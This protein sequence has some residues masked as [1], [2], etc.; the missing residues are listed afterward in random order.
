M[1]LTN[2]ER[3]NQTSKVL[4]ANVY[5]GIP[6]RQWYEALRANFFLLEDGQVLTEFA[7]VRANPAGSLTQARNNAAGP[8]TGIVQDLS[9]FSNAV[10]L[11]PDIAANGYQYV[12]LATYNDFS[13]AR[14]DKWIQPQKVPQT[15]GQPSIGY[16][17]QLYDG[18][19][20]AGGTLI[21][22]SDGQTGSG[23]TASVGWLFNYDQGVLILS[24]DFK[25]TISDPYIVGFRYIGET[26]KDIETGGGG[27]T[28]DDQRIFFTTAQ[29]AHG[30]PNGSQLTPVYKTTVSGWLEAQANSTET[31]AVG[32]ITNAPDVDT[33]EITMAGRVTVS[34]HS[35]IVNEYYFLDVNSQGALTVFTP[36]S[37]VV[38]PLLWV[39][40]PDTVI[41]DIQR[42]N[43]L[44]EEPPE[45]EVRIQG[46]E[47]SVSGLDTTVSGL[48]EDVA[49]LQAQG[50]LGDSSGAIDSVAFWT[51]SDSISGVNEFKWNDTL[52]TL[53]IN[54]DIAMDGDINITTGSID[55][56]SNTL[57]L[58][59]TEGMFITGSG[60]DI[61]DFGNENLPV[62][63]I[64]G[65]SLGIGTRAPN[66]LLTLDGYLSFKEQDMS[67]L[68]STG[69][70]KM[71]ANSAGAVIWQRDDGTEFNLLTQGGGDIDGGSFLDVYN[72]TSD[73]D[74]GSFI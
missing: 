7:T 72:N 15:N 48:E 8:L 20:N 6:Q 5:D 69:Y 53:L 52:K 13:S 73:I 34:G 65:D 16:S 45:I 11:T 17:I 54:G 47:T 41:I 19:P 58:D 50:S 51:D 63:T 60:I 23:E 44:T 27:G 74:G 28:G 10:R 37:G 9:Q 22:T 38:Q 32:L 21:N 68:V 30:Y 57:W 36:V 35:L 4:A 59:E 40:D 70:G 55:M 14:L 29:T 33:L 24:T 43:E 49:T 39:E 46:L 67:P 1:G 3:I 71:Y 66:E 18:D 12:A 26:V 42:A 2:Q 62:F 64:S 25:D 61:V 56:Q 31:L